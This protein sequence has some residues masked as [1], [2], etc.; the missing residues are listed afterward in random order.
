M[1]T[2]SLTVC[3]T[4]GLVVFEPAID[5]FFDADDDSF[6]VTF[7]VLVPWAGSVSSRGVQ[8]RFATV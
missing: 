6:E 1:T 2:C 3:L 8:T 7:D 4:P 5:L